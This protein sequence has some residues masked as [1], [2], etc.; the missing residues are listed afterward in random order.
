M[1]FFR[2]TLEWS[3][4]FDVVHGMLRQGWCVENMQHGMVVQFLNL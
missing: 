2:T 3:G 4:W 1:A